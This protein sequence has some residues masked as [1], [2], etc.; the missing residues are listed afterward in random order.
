MSVLGIDIGATNLRYGLLVDEKLEQ[1]ASTKSRAESPETLATQCKE[2][3]ERFGDVESVGIAMPGP[4]D[5]N[6]VVDGSPNFPPGTWVDVQF[7]D[8]LSS[9]L[10]RKFIL[11][12]DS[13]AALVGEWKL[14]AAKGSK[15]VVLLTI[16]T[17]IGGAAVVDGKI[18]R[19]HN[20]YAGEFGHMFIG[21]KGRQCGAGHDG[22]AEAWASGRAMEN[23]VS[24]EQA[25]D[26]FA[27]LLIS[28]EKIFDPEMIVLAGGMIKQSGY[29]A[30]IRGK[31]K[32]IGL[33]TDVKVGKFGEWA[34]VAGAA[35]LARDAK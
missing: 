26:V 7:R 21:P 22:C 1:T 16:G 14:G 11:D 19:G 6:G 15:N 33:Q 27:R 5:K 13:V 35:L 17:G 30:A 12:R 32:L 28:L 9:T 24:V 3:V 18:L 2:I 8:I 29:L 4:I 25:T 20:G 31:T 34:G 23:G 10:D